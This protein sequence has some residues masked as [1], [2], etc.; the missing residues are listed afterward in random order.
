MPQL[1]LLA[2]KQT[3]LQIQ[4]KTPE[5]NPHRCKLTTLKVVSVDV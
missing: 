3:P 4:D 5:P 2:P 1:T